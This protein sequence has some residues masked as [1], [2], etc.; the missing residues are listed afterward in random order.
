MNI[1]PRKANPM[2]KKNTLPLGITQLVI[3]VLVLALVSPPLSAQDKLGII[4][5][6]ER[7][8]FNSDPMGVLDSGGAEVTDSPES[9]RD[10][11]PGLDFE[12]LANGGFNV[13][14]T[15]GEGGRRETRL[16]RA[17]S[18]VTETDRN[19]NEI[20]TEYDED[21]N[22]IRETMNYPDGSVGEWTRNVDGSSTE[23][24]RDADDNVVSTEIRDENDELISGE[25]R[26]PNGT[27]D[28]ARRDPDGSLVLERRDADDNLVRTRTRHPDGDGYTDVDHTTGTR[29]DTRRERDEDGKLK[30][31][32]TTTTNEDGSSTERTATPNGIE[33]VEKNS[34]KRVT[35]R[36]VH[37]R[38][39]GSKTEIE[40]GEDGEKVREL[41][42][43]KDG[44]S[45]ERWKGEDGSMEGVI[46][47]KNGNVKEKFLKTKDGTT[48][49]SK[50]TDW[51][52]KDTITYPDGSTKDIVQQKFGNKT[53]IVIEKDKNGKITGHSQSSSRL[54]E[55]GQNYYEKRGG[56]NWN[57]L[58][59][60]EKAK[61]EIAAEK[62]EGPG[63]FSP[64][65]MS[66]YAKGV[67]ERARMAAEMEKDVDK[68]ATEGASGSDA[69]TD[70][71]PEAPKLSVDEPPTAEKREEETA[72][73]RSELEKKSA[74][75]ASRAKAL[76]K[77][78][79]QALE[80]DDRARIRK[81]GDEMDRNMDESIPV[82]EELLEMDARENDVKDEAR[83]IIAQAIRK[84]AA[85]RA[86][87]MNNQ[88]AELEDHTQAVAGKFSWVS[89]GAEITI[90]TTDEARSADARR[91]LG[92]ANLEAIAR[93]EDMPGLLELR[94]GDLA[95]DKDAV[96]AAK[97]FLAGRKE[98]AQNQVDMGT[99]ERNTITAIRAAG[100][101]ADVLDTLVGGKIASGGGKLV[102]RGLKAAKGA[103]AAKVAP[104]LV[105]SGTQTLD[106]LLDMGSRGARTE[107]LDTLLDVGGRGA[108]DAAGALEERM[109][110]MTRSTPTEYIPFDQLSPR[111]LEMLATD[112]TIFMPG[113]RRAVVDIG[114]ISEAA[115]PSPSTIRRLWEKGRNLTSEE[116]ILKV[117]LILSGRVPATGP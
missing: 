109:V 96:A 42:T 100:T 114:R 27:R 24:V 69:P 57:D 34:D 29:T 116:I 9:L 101:V 83:Y 108:R 12:L 3:I 91:N 52:D 102:S 98:F 66:E 64:P 54:L 10:K 45:R 38:D 20:E 50:K 73:R 46:R 95:K 53:R 39:K 43:R 11:I 8:L 74:E 40:Y 115:A 2:L 111:Q 107:T 92:T 56:R 59:D 31:I 80:D 63:P 35:K 41:E 105:Q 103:R 18:T 77:Q 15:D 104:R 113:V 82:D 6:F 25:R 79:D 5:R 81:I 76:Q 26:N 1:Y 86:Q 106:T 16:D 97:K 17:G 72:K 51:W 33:T 44:S 62:A 49:R 68:L 37:D 32:K 117:D 71:V 90:K 23:T 85:A 60:T 78:L 110:R 61:H 55:P 88:D 75:Y 89:A 36:T 99:S 58:S 70:A 112:S 48:V 7:A 19:G 47:D 28:T 14:E 84:D 67:V 87:D 13:T 21:G 65:E 93:L 94:L 4:N 22:V 30:S